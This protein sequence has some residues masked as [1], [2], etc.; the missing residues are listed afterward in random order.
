MTDRAWLVGE[1]GSA[2]IFSIP[3]VVLTAAGARHVAHYGGSWLLYLVTACW[4]W[5]PGV[6]LGIAA[7]LQSR[8][9]SLRAG[10]RMSAGAAAAMSLLS[11]FVLWGFAHQGDVHWSLWAMWAAA[12]LATLVTIAAVVALVPSRRTACDDARVHS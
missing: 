3:T 7:L 5:G 11:V 4:F 6:L 2:A 1:F 8:P 9:R 10:W 12:G